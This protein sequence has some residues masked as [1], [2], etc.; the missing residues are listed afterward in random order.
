M[1][2]SWT[3][4]VLPEHRGKG[5]GSLLLNAV[6]AELH[7]LGATELSLHVLPRRKDARRF[8]ERHG[9]TTFAPWLSSPVTGCRRG[10]R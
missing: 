4:S 7:A 2:E 5:V 8:Y 1:P 9:V 10:H 6:R 3:L